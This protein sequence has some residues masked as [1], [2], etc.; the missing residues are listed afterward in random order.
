MS[1]ILLQLAN[2]SNAEGLEYD[3]LKLKARTAETDGDKEWI[4]T[5]AEISYENGK[6]SKGQLDDIALLLNGQFLADDE[7]QDNPTKAFHDIIDKTENVKDINKKINELYKQHRGDKNWEKAYMDFTDNIGVND[8]DSWRDAYNVFENIIEQENMNEREISRRVDELYKRHKGEEIWDEAYE[9]WNEEEPNPMDEFS[10]PEGSDLSYAQLESFINEKELQRYADRYNVSVDELKSEILKRYQENNMGMSD[11][12]AIRGHQENVIEDLVSSNGKD[13]WKSKNKSEF[14]TYNGAE[15][16]GGDDDS[17]GIL[18][19]ETPLSE[20]DSLK[21]S[22]QDKN[23]SG[24]KLAQQIENSNLSEDQKRELRNDLLNRRRNWTEEHNRRIGRE[25]QMHAMIDNAKRNGQSPQQVLDSVSYDMDIEK[26]SEEYNRLKDLVLEGTHLNKE[27]GQH[28]YNRF[29]IGS[30]KTLRKPEDREKLNELRQALQ[31]AGLQ[32]AKIED[33]YEDIGANMYW[34]N[35]TSGDTW[36]L[37]PRDWMD[38]MNGNATKEEI[39]DRVKNGKYSGAFKWGEPKKQESQDSKEWRFKPDNLAIVQKLQGLGLDTGS[40]TEEDF[41]VA[42]DFLNRFGGNKEKKNNSV[43]KPAGK[44]LEKVHKNDYK[45]YKFFGSPVEYDTDGKH[46]E[47]ELPLRKRSYTKE[48][49]ASSLEDAIKQLMKDYPKGYQVKRHSE[50]GKETIHGQYEEDSK[51]LEE[52]LEW[53][54]KNKQGK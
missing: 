2:D 28:E 5:Q 29:N 17:A 16:I 42:K 36:V 39:V 23:E 35:I 9:R 11:K 51:T 3:D 10:G 41:E 44:N 8:S 13:D 20:F 22:I 15:V 6:I 47:I 52:L 12:D 53:V 34:T 21:Q 43:E 33:G 40:M 26:G 46:G 38:Y 45:S 48:Y 24:A 49:K 37:N 7:E 19:D 32:D 14:A 30:N 31:D 18:K 4:R 50:N 25:S 54:K 27:S 1:K